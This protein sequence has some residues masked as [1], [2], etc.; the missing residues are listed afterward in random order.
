VDAVWYFGT[1][2]GASD[3]ERASAANMKQTWTE[4]EARD[5]P[6]PRGE[7]PDFL[8]RATQVKNI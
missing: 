3:V 2:G 7:G 4:W 1:R 8:R 5:W 6:G